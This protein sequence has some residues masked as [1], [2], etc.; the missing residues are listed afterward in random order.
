MLNGE[1]PEH[2]QVDRGREPEMTE[3]T[4]PQPEKARGGCLTA[5]LIVMLILNPLVAIYYLV[6]G[7]SLA[8]VVPGFTPG[9][10]IL[11]ALLGFAG[12]SDHYGGARQPDLGPDGMTAANGFQ[13]PAF[14]SQPSTLEYRH[15]SI[16]EDL[17]N[18]TYDSLR[19]VLEH[20]RLSCT[21]WLRPLS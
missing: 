12:G 19:A 21:R 11:F 6:A 17:A 8:T 3:M 16:Q 14:S 5:F 4:Q 20:L 18:T 2:S 15:D 13:Q 10:M 7:D 1:K 9:M